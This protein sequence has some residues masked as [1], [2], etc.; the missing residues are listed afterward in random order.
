MPGFEEVIER[1]DCVEH[2]GF[3]GLGSR[4]SGE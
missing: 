4:D 1:L 3:H 2:D